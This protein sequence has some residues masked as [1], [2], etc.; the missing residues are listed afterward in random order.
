MRGL[1]QQ[2]NT[3]APGVTVRVKDA[4]LTLPGGPTKRA[5]PCPPAISRR[6]NPD[7]RVGLTLTLTLTLIET[8]TLT[9]TPAHPQSAAGSSR[10]A[11]RNLRREI[12]SGRRRRRRKT[13]RPGL[14][15]GSAAVRVTRSTCSMSSSSSTS[16]SSSSRSSSIRSSSG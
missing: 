16:N 11:R 5:N 12:P 6:V 8:L 15:R 10:R 7:P 1:T 14:E 2:G 4:A 13:R 9:D 3:G